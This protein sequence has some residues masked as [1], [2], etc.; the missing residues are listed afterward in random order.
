MQETLNTTV[1]EPLVQREDTMTTFAHHP[2]APLS[3]SAKFSP[4]WEGTPL[5][6]SYIMAAPMDDAELMALLMASPLYQKL[7][8]IKKGV[9]ERGFGGHRMEPGMQ[10]NRNY[11]G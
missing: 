11:Y 2:A 10:N 9:A 7:E 8:Q 4:E 3:A 1:T 6:H 5:P